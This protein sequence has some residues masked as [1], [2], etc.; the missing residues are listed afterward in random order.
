MI[1]I[2]ISSAQTTWMRL[3]DQEIAGK[4]GR[5]YFAFL[6]VAGSLLLLETTPRVIAATAKLSSPL[7]ASALVLAGLLPEYLV[8]A[9]IFGIYGTGAML[10]YRLVRR[11]ELAA[12]SAAGI[13]TVRVTAAYVVL[14]ALNACMI[15]AVLGWFQP[16]GAERIAKVDRDVAI[17][18]YGTTFESR[19][20]IP[21]GRNGTM[22]FDHVDPDTGVLQGVFA[23][24]AGRTISSRQASV[25][26]TS[27]NAVRV[28]FRHGLI[29]DE[30][31]RSPAKAAVSVV[32]FN[33]LDVSV[34]DDASV[35]AIR[36]PEPFQK[37][38]EF[39]ELLAIGNDGKVPQA[40][41]AAAGAEALYRV[42]VPLLSLFVAWLGFVLGLADRS[43]SSIGAVTLG[44]CLIVSFLRLAELIRSIAPAQALAANV[45]LLAF[46][47]A[48][49]TLLTDLSRRF[50]SG[51]IDHALRRAW[52]Q[53]SRWIENQR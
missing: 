52:H 24:L 22:I 41:R 16:Q 51:F 17:G 32:R 48:T 50:G 25:G 28:E 31:T 26:R 37:L 47:A 19:M 30:H 45:G 5:Y 14:A 42:T 23:R 29:I 20:P 4:I 40:I 2:S 44:A 43:V 6:A 36:S 3:L 12:W 38:A 11:N 8:M 46:A 21:I 9:G 7:V 27:A 18:R 35:T 10:A 33:Q 34:P 13:S 39:P 49:C 1:D 53:A 15:M